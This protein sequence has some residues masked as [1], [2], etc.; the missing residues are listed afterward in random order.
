M[1]EIRTRALVLR[2]FDQRESDRLVHLYTEETGRI[3]AIAKGA[4][5]SRRRFPGTLEILTLLDARIVD[6]PRASLMRLEGA[7]VLSPFEGLVNELGR[8]AIACQL[9]ELLDRVTGEREANPELFRFAIGVLDVLRS[10]DP[11]RLLALLVLMKT[12]AWLGYRPLLAH[13]ALCGDAITS[14]ARG[15]GFEPRHGGAVCTRC[16]EAGVPPVSP[17]LLLALEAGLRNPL[18]DRVGLGLDERA[19][20]RA[21]LLLDRFFR[22]HIGLELR[23]AP[24]L[25][26]MIPARLDGGRPAGENAPSPSVGGVRVV[27]R[28]PGGPENPSRV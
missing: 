19:V 9:L 26:Q 2:C 7:R 20:S 3:S 24:F 17:D 8:Y 12:V 10:E 6:P 14:G 25:R 1:A 27:V 15:V 5:R 28:S 16:R 22:F 23:T 4:R 18:R 11:D 21:E 13:C